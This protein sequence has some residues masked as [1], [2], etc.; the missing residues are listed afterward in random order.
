MSV[1]TIA[2]PTHG[3]FLVEAPASGE[4]RGWL[5]G[6]HGYAENAPVQMERL[7]AMP[8][9]DAWVCVAVQGLNRFYRGTSQHVAASWM[10]SEDREL[11]IHDNLAYVA[12]VVEHVV[13]HW[14]AAGGRVV[15]AGFSQGVAM[16]FRAACAS[17][18]PVSAVVALGGDVPPELGADALRRVRRVF[19][20]RGDHDG[21]YSA[22]Q[23]AADQVRVRDAGVDLTAYL[24]D[25]DHVWTT[26][27]S[28]EAGHFLQALA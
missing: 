25:D 3:R 20:G 16:A 27:F 10:T 17:V 13:T 9:A 1:H 12:A 23:F 19:Y 8:G 5:F 26:V 22:E 28:E 18:R 15:F 21:W 14:P 24:F 7:L 6:F 2:A 4:R 11:A